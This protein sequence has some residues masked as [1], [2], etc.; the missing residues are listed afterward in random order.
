MGSSGRRSARGCDSR[1]A[2]RPTL[3]RVSVIAVRMLARVPPIVAIAGAW[4]AGTLLVHTLAALPSGGAYV[5]LAL[6]A[7]L[8]LRFRATRWVVW[9]LAGFAWT[10][11][12]A[13]QRLDERL[14]L[15]SNGRDVAIRGYVEGFPTLAPGQATFSFVVGEPLPPGVPPRVRLTWYEPPQPIAAGDALTLGARLRVPHGARNPGGFDY[16][17]WLLVTDHGATGYVRSGSRAADAPS[18][19]AR[20]WLALRARIAERIGAVL[21]DGDAAALVTA[22]AIGE[23]YRFS[24]QNWADFRRTGTSHL[25][26]VSGMHIGMLGVLVFVVLRALWIRLP[27]PLASYDLEVAA[28]ASIASTAYYAALTGLAIP[29]QRTL[30]MIA[31]ALGLLVARRSAGPFQV[32]AASLLAA[33]VWDPFAPLSASFWLSFVA[34]AA[35][36]ALSAP[37]RLRSGPRTRARRV[38]HAVVDVGALQ[39]SI[40]CALLPL[41]A[42]FFGEISLLGP[43]V[44]LIAIPLFNLVLVPLT[45]LAT[46]LVQ[47]DGLAATVAPPLLHAVGWLAAQTAAAL[48]VLASQ[49]FAALA[50]AMPPTATVA[51]AACGVALACPA[52]PLPGRRL[53]WLAVLPMFSPASAAPAP[54]DVR[55][56]VLDV[57]QGLSVSVATHSHRLLFDAGPSFRSGFDSGDDIVLPALAAGSPRTLDRLVVSHA[58][59]DHAGG[60]RAV[61]AAFPRADVLEGPDVALPGRACERGERWEWDGVHFSIL[62][63]PPEFEPRGNETSCVLKIDARAGSVLITG[64]VEGR[65]EAALVRGGDVASDVVVVPHHGSPTS[66]SPAFVAATRPRYALVSAGFA[67]RWGFPKPEV[68]ARWA[69]S[70]AAVAVTGE[71]GALAVSLDSHGITV[72]AERDR[73]PHYWQAPSAPPE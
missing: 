42:V 71:R 43:V 39:W 3:T 18:S 63:P 46:L 14:A 9:G 53:G 7:M 30:L 54:G 32:L 51:L 66:S 56:D 4:F 50:V 23:R 22:L 8:A 59:N 2:R 27:Q 34:V 36:L 67:N 35:L 55:V 24:D 48:H 26:A 5:P 33:L 28:A 41:T 72:V 20:S 37:R 58:D 29:A 65:G 47:V 25:V 15:T 57:G 21:G 31:I 16:E 12:S 62:H 38:A 19:L 69:G 44:N 6:G 64:D 52:H 17:R 73:D 40:G 61:L 13:Q 10:A 60:A 45:L 1:A 70:G 11:I 68:R 49:R